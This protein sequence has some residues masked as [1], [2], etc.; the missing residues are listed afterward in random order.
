MA[1]LPFE[2]SLTLS[3]I[4][5]SERQEL[6][7]FVAQVERFSRSSF[8]ETPG[9]KLTLSAKKGEAM[10]IEYPHAG[11]EAVRAV[12]PVF[13]QLYTDTERGSAARAMKILKAS[14]HTRATDEG[15]QLIQLLK[16]HGRGLREFRR[17]NAGLALLHND[18]DLDFGR[19]IDLW[20][21][22]D[23][24]H[25]DEV[26]ANV[27]SA[28]PPEIMQMQLHTALVGFRNGYWVLANLVRLCLAEPA[29]ALPSPAPNG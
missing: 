2:L 19:V 24:M 16:D 15:R 28:W 8:F 10:Q 5:R 20:L 12:M 25:F 29:L 21:N 9:G 14:A 13:R 27:I 6:V 4:S 26:K 23:Y 7:R 22:G 17:S 11:D 1:K 18:V 3:P